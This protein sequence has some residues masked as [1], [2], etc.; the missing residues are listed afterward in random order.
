M[1]KVDSNF[2]DN[3][4]SQFFKPIIWCFSGISLFSQGKVFKLIYSVTFEEIRFSSIQCVTKITLSFLISLLRLHL[5]IWERTPSED[6]RWINKI[7]NNFPPKFPIHDFPLR[8]FFIRQ[9]NTTH[10][11]KKR[12]FSQNWIQMCGICWIFTS[13]LLNEF[14]WI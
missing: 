2:G 12:Q 6:M 14:S 9:Q 11:S 10:Y 4:A 5:A 13:K 1:V 8:F 3:F 7:I